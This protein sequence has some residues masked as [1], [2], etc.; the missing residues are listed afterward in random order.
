MLNPI[1]PLNSVP[2]NI[3]IRKLD[4][5]EEIV[6]EENLVEEKEEAP[7]QKYKS[8]MDVISNKPAH[9]LPELPAQAS[10]KAV[11]VLAELSDGVIPPVPDKTLPGLPSN[12]GGTAV[13]VLSQLSD[14]VIPPVPP[15]VNS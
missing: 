1:N 11:E 13:D 6:N 15:K 12:A 7:V 5:E 10:A 4:A 14:G 3:K 8:P 9:V 2:V